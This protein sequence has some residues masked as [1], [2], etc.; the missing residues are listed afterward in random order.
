ME[1]GGGECGVTGIGLRAAVAAPPVVRDRVRH[2]PSE[3][4]GVF[5]GPAEQPGGVHELLGDAADV[6]AGAPEAPCASLLAR[7][8]EVE[9]GNLLAELGGLLGGRQ[10]AG[11]AA[12]DDQ[13]VVV[14]VLRL[15]DGC[16]SARERRGD[17]TEARVC[18]C[19]CVC[20]CVWGGRRCLRL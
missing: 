15:R 1:D 4:L 14:A 18:V 13:V 9:H 20:V 8:D 16:F 17:Q 3:G 2:A 7:L 10:P 11:P 19:V 5:D 6:N 12:D